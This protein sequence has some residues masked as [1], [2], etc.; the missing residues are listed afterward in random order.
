M[1]KQV[2]TQS[3]GL[4]AINTGSMVDEMFGDLT[5]ETSDILIPKILLMQPSSQFVGAEKARVGE[6]VLS[7][8]GK[9]VGSIAEPFVVV[10]FFNRKSIDVMAKQ[11][12]KFIKN[13]PFNPANAQLPREDKED[14]VEI[15]RYHRMDYFCMVPD[16]MK[17]GSILPAVISFKSTGYKSGNVIVSTWADINAVNMKAREEG[18]LGDL[19]LP[20]SKS[21]I[22]SGDKLQNQEKQTYCVPRVQV[23]ADVPEEIQRA[24]IQWVHT[25]KN[26]PAVVKV[27]ED[28]TEQE[29][30]QHTS[31]TGAF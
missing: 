11:G 14:G 17:E 10:P 29:V 30:P 16:L 28:E 8:T 20:F 24:C 5:I 22:I 21:F 6:Y 26:T 4:P 2:V 9:K 15:K 31:E 7:T 23:G 13:I 12:N 18:R 3:A 19:K 25:L 1:S 27:D